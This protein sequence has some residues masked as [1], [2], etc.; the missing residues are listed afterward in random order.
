L[1]NKRKRETYNTPST[2]KTSTAAEAS[3]SPIFA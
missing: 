1:Q 2:C 3:S